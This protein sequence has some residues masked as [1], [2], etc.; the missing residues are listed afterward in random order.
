MTRGTSGRIVI[1]VDPS[2]KRRLH[3]AVALRGQTLKEWFLACAEDLLRQCE[4]LAPNV[5]HS[6]AR[7]PAEEVEE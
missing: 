7:S 3:A 5:R 2:L 6:D 1:E 4:P